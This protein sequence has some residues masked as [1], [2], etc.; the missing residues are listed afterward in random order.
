MMSVFIDYDC[1]SIY[2]SARFEVFD[3][4][5]L[6]G[7]VIHVFDEDGTFVDLVGLDDLW[8]FKI[9]SRTF[10]RLRSVALALLFRGRGLRGGR[11]GQRRRLR[12]ASLESQKRERRG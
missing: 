8:R 1:H 6:R 2:L 10:L 5:V 11:G 9:N 3:D 12:E 7:C 4:L